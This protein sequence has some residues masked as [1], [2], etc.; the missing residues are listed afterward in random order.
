MSD[1]IAVEQTN[2]TVRGFLPEQQIFRE[3]SEMVLDVSFR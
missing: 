3:K 1:L 2:Q